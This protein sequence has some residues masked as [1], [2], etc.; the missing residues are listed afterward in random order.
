M[1]PSDVALNT[2]LDDAS[3]LPDIWS[4]QKSDAELKKNQKRNWNVHWTVPENETSSSSQYVNLPENKNLP[5]ILGRLDGAA[6]FFEVDVYATFWEQSRSFWGY[7]SRRQSLEI[8]HWLSDIR[9]S[10]RH[11]ARVLALENKS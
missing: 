6:L 4:L 2:M 7:K 8:A 11:R 5:W 3:N 10:Q 1:N 9:Q